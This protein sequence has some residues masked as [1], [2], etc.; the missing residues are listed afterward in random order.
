MSE[1]CCCFLSGDNKP[2]STLAD[3]SAGAWKAAKKNQGIS[4][5]ARSRLVTLIWN[6]QWVL[7]MV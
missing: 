2:L 3:S 4:T 6:I 7:N 5:Q 1:G